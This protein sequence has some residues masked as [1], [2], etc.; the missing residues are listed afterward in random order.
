MH[1]RTYQYDAPRYPFGQG[2]E[3]KEMRVHRNGD[4]SGDIQFVV[5]NEEIDYTADTMGENG[6]SQV[7]IPYEVIEQ[8]VLDKLASD[9]VS[10]LEQADHHDLK[11][12]LFR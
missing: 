3:T 6:T 12:L 2:S 7:R 1:S 5:A 8:I 9:R 4:Y 10:A 11:K